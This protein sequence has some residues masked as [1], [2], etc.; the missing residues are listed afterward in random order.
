[1]EK[2]YVMYLRVASAEQLRDTPMG[3]LD[4]QEA[5][6]QEFAERKLGRRISEENIYRDVAPSSP[7]EQRDGLMQLLSRVERD[8]IF[9]VLVYDIS[10]LTRGDE[11]EIDRIVDALHKNCTTVETPLDGYN[12]KDLVGSQLLRNCLLRQHDYSEYFNYMA[13]WLHNERK[14]RVINRKRGQTDARH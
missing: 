4:R 8:D 1:M 14:R 11:N 13:K 5:V 10:R 2:Q 12:V 9:G 3:V 6:M 7:I